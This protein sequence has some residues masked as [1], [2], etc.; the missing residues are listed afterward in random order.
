MGEGCR[1][2]SFGAGNF[3]RIDGDDLLIAVRLTPRSAKEG[4]GGL[5]RDSGGAVWLQAQVRAV[6]EKGKANDALIR[7]LAKQL[8]IPAKDIVVDSGGSSRLKRL[9]L[10]GRAHDAAAMLKDWI[11]T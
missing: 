6:P 10:I 4:A 9:R 5:W 11:E 7:L 8:H 2:E 3:W 1:A